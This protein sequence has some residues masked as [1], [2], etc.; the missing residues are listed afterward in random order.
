MVLGFAGVVVVT[1]LIIEPTE[2]LWR[3]VLHLSAEQQDVPA[4]D[5]EKIKFGQ[6][7]VASLTGQ[8]YQWAALAHSAASKTPIRGENIGGN[9]IAQNMPLPL[10]V[11]D[12]EE[13]IKFANPA[14]AEYIGMPADELV[15]K[16]VYMA[17]DMAF[18]S[19]ETFDVWLKDAK[20]NNATASTTWE[21]V[22]LNL[23]D[24]HPEKLFDLA[25]YYNR[26]NPDGNETIMAL[27]DHT[28]MYSQDD[29]AVS[30]MA[31][32]VHEL[33]TPLTL[34]RGY[35]EVFDKELGPTI[36]DPELQGFMLKMQKM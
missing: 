34:L 28:K 7:L 33:R 3:T 9:F 24:S 30:F 20:I 36:T 11:L 8:I 21:R 10:L 27:F 22:K 29:Q 6:E 4:P 32:S 16:N 1:K 35:I 19:E 26:D 2:A 15:G 25:T 31:L 13:I 17:V 18:P 5:V 23:N 12:S 14:A